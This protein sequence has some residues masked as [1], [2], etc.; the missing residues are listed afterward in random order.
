K[1]CECFEGF[2]FNHIMNA[3]IEDDL[4][5]IDYCFDIL[6]NQ[7][8]DPCSNQT[9]DV[10]FSFYNPGGSEDQE[11]G[12]KELG[13]VVIPIDLEAFGITSIA[14]LFVPGRVQLRA[15]S[16]GAEGS[17]CSWGPDGTSIDLSTLD[18]NFV[19][20]YS[21]NL[22]F[23]DGCTPNEPDDFRRIAFN[24]SLLDQN[25]GNALIN[26]YDD[27]V[28]NTFNTN[29]KFSIVFSDLTIDL[30]NI[31][32]I[33][34]E[35]NV[36]GE[37]P[38]VLSSNPEWGCGNE[39]YTF[40]QANG[41]S[42][43]PNVWSANNSYYTVYR[44]MCEQLISE[45]DNLLEM[46]P[47]LYLEDSEFLLNDPLVGCS[48]EFEEGIQNPFVH[49]AEGE[50]YITY[51]NNNE[52]SAYAEALDGDFELELPGS[53]LAIEFDYGMYLNE[54]A[55]LNLW[56]FNPGEQVDLFNP[57]PS[58]QLMG[59]ISMPIYLDWYEVTINMI[60]DNGTLG[61][62][63]PY[64]D[65]NDELSCTHNLVFEAPDL[66]CIS[67]P[68]NSQQKIRVTVV[69][70]SALTECPDAIEGC[71]LFPYNTGE[72]VFS[73]AEE[74]VC[75]SPQSL[76]LELACASHIVTY[77]CGTCSVSIGGAEN[78]A[79]EP[80]AEFNMVEDPNND[81]FFRVKRNTFGYPTNDI[82]FDPVG[83][84]PAQ[85]YNGE[86]GFPLDALDEDG[87]LPQTGL[88]PFAD[89]DAAEEGEAP[90]EEATEE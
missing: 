30:D 44:T 28:F 45:R 62:N 40:F 73:L 54:I 81:E 78:T 80:S 64:S 65:S 66:G 88:L 77:R 83:P 55:D 7:G 6:P 58:T 70:P 16:I 32:V 69:W 63:I 34:V 79:G 9:F 37:N 15:H 3:T 85:I 22:G 38:L 86:T 84:A 71:P 35:A 24:F 19:N 2:N 67:Y 29:S 90:A 33:D 82:S 20:Y 1:L 13:W 56:D 43:L 23:P 57:C 72:M 61:P 46:R 21:E 76:A 4:D 47:Q 18:P 75:S 14:D 12:M 48:P 10:E 89:A 26:W 25:V 8:I 59:R 52:Y 17:H 60:N 42:A 5:P 27:S 68:C 36:L 53:S 31:T 74:C 11:N 41:G 49:V 51:N 39:G 87:I 50:D